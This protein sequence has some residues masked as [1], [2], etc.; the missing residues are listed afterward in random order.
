METPEIRKTKNEDEN[1]IKRRFGEIGKTLE[2]RF[3]S[4]LDYSKLSKLQDELIN[5]LKNELLFG[6]NKPD[7]KNIMTM[8]IEKVPIVNQ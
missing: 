7:Q 6:I 2:D 1:P 3:S 5:K 4:L 8:H